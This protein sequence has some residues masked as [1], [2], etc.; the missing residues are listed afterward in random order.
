MQ[1]LVL[2]PRNVVLQGKDVSLG[3]NCTTRPPSQIF[4]SIFA[5]AL[6]KSILSAMSPN[7]CLTI[8]KLCLLS[9]G[10]PSDNGV[11]NGRLLFDGVVIATH[12]VGPPHL[13]RQSADDVYLRYSQRSLG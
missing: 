1:L 6:R 4:P 7:A 10:N 13:D 3:P 2:F 11:L 12:A 8:A 5:S 9:E